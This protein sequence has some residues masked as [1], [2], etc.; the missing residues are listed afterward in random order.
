MAEWA[1]RGLRIRPTI[2]E[3][4]L[5]ESTFVVGPSGPMFGRD[6]DSVLRRHYKPAEASFLIPRRAG[7]S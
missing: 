5:R 4:V 3:H 7:F 2:A 6:R 1:G